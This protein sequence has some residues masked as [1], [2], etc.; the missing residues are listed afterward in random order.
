M[1]PQAH[2]QLVS[3]SSHLPHLIASSLASFVLDPVHPKEQGTLCANGFRDS[4]RIASGSPEMWRDIALA[5]RENLS[6]AMG[7][8][9]EELGSLQRALK[10]GNARAISGLL[11]RAKQR[12]DR[13]AAKN[14]TP[15]PE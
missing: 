1:T 12:R 15:S 11:Q 8:F 4:T 5:N 10:K 3:R 9:I 13:W 6:H 2:D 7:S 14:T